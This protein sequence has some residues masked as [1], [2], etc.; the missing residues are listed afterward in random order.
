MSTQ[1]LVE[2][3]RVWSHFGEVCE[4]PDSFE[5]LC[6]PVN[7]EESW[8]L[9]VGLR[10]N[11]DETVT[12]EE[13]TRFFRSLGARQ[14]EIIGAQSSTTYG[15]AVFDIAS[16][17]IDQYK[18][19]DLFLRAHDHQLFGTVSRKWEIPEYMQSH[20]NPYD[21]G[22]W[23]LDF[24]P[25][26]NECQ[27]FFFWDNNP[28]AVASGHFGYRNPLTPSFF[29]STWEEYLQHRRQERMDTHPDR[30]RITSLAEYHHAYRESGHLYKTPDAR[31]FIHKR[32]ITE[33]GYRT[34]GRFFVGP[35]RRV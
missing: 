22:L 30:D 11:G 20:D 27:G 2:G 3:D 25:P 21:D 7:G 16:L 24:V 23:H 14:N 8:E 33:A 10:F 4:L 26:D 34:F 12:D 29:S 19:S 28:T 5:E 1:E 35:I 15:V 9:G 17:A 32:H 13:I 18:Q 31:T 6:G